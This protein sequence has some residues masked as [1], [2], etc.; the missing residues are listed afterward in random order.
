MQVLWLPTTEKK[1]GF[2]TVPGYLP[3]A[4]GHSFRHV[5]VE[6]ED[7]QCGAPKRSKFVYK[8]Y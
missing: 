8:P 5:W 3:G 1:L 4:S 6:E 7:I 2:R